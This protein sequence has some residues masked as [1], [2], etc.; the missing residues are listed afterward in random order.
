MKILS[1]IIRGKMETALLFFIL[2]IVVVILGVGGYFTYDYLQYKKS[3]DTQLETAQKDI[4]VT[5]DAV[6]KEEKARLSNMKYIVDQVNTTNLDIYNTFT[7]NIDDTRKV[8]DGLTG[9]QKKILLGVDSLLR[10]STAPIAPNTTP[11]VIDL[12]SLPGS[13]GVNIDLLKHVTAINGMTFKE[14]SE[15][16]GVKFCGVTKSGVSTRCMEFPNKDGNTVFTNLVE[17]KPIIMAG[18][19]EFSSSITLANT[20]GGSLKSSST[21]QPL[22][23]SSNKFVQV[24]NQLSVGDNAASLSESTLPTMSIYSMDG[25]DA[26][27]VS[28]K[29]NAS[30]LRVD[31]TGRVFLSETN[32]F[33]TDANK[34]LLMKTS[35]LDIQATNSDLRLKGN[36]INLDGNINITG[37]VTVN[38]VPLKNDSS[39]NIIAPSPSPSGNVQI[40]GFQTMK[41]QSQWKG[42]GKVL[43][44]M[45][46]QTRA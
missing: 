46:V 36:T 18:D 13:T 40:E 22:T 17:N 28:T 42:M 3:L 14:L 16:N 1:F 25:K 29:T 6:T 24:A 9:S 37:N 32:S 21:E 8:T 31:S 38:G 30:A 2:L 35:G 26:M 39:T 4:V 15:T 45:L 41:S 23:I 20:A 7:S 27:N 5:K 43:P 12:M 11:T 34:K 33:E 19:T 10:F 44:S